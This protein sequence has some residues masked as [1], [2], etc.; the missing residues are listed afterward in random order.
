MAYSLL[1]GLSGLWVWLL[2]RIR[3][4]G[5]VVLIEPNSLILTSEIGAM[6]ALTIWALILAIREAAKGKA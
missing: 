2:I 1:A 5:Q 6:I 4:E 3:F